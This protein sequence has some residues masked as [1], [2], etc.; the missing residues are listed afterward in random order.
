[1]EKHTIDRQETSFFSDIANTLVYKQDELKEF[2]HQPFD[3]KAFAQQ[4]KDK[5]ANYNHSY[6][7][8][9]RDS[10][11]K[12]YA[13]VN[14]PD[15]VVQNTLLLEK[16]DTFTVTTGHQLNL[17]TGPLYFIYKIVHVIQLAKTLKKEYPSYNFVPV[18]WMASEDH[19]FAEINHLNLFNQKRTWES[20]QT[21]AVGKFNLQGF[22]ALKHEVKSL[23]ENQ[24]E[25]AHLVEESYA[26]EDN[27][28]QAT[29]KLVNQLFGE[30]GLVII[31]AD[32]P[33]LKALYRPVLFKEIGEQFSEKE[34]QKS[35]DKL[36][37]KGFHGQ[38]HPREINL[39]FMEN[40]KRERIIKT[41]EGNF[42]AGDDVS[43]SAIEML[44]LI[45][46]KPELI[47]PN[48]V[49]RPVYQEW[50]LP[51]LVYVGGGGEM[52][53]WLQLK[54]VFDALD[55]QYPLIQVRNSVQ[56]VDGVSQKKMAKLGYEFADFLNSTDAL[57]KDFVLN[58]SDEEINFEDLNKAFDVLE[59]TVER[60]VLSVD[61]ALENYGKGELT[62]MRKQIENMQSK[63]IRHQKKKYD[64]TLKN[65]DSVHDR[66]FP[67]GGLQERKENVLAYFSK[68]GIDNF[69]NLLKEHMDP[70]EN[71]LIILSEN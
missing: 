31:D 39:F 14:T 7:K 33:E 5:D 19:D 20:E 54:G 59:K 69:L 66:L 60:D 23:F 35:T 44:E 56:I 29:L 37:E 13:N 8:V 22:E 42:T 30:E 17:Y 53:Y 61:K 65:I 3:I 34:V 24:P 63:L 10:L 1:M 2:I 38:V 64:D 21:G 18:Y 67:G 25:I 6:R 36:I 57:K 28:A 55:L 9:L 46:G 16:K 12:Q 11:I 48:V 45:D 49:L 58:N 41:E 62:K 43:F 51:N 70:L 71:D 26:E 4:I 32:A 47:S 15:A 68:Y 27:L 50:I 40:G 52:A